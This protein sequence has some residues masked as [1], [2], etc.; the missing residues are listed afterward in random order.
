MTDLPAGQ[1]VPTLY[2]TVVPTVGLPINQ[3]IEKAY[4]F[5]GPYLGTILPG[6]KT[7]QLYSHTTE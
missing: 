4:T 5:L 6:T 2:N 1:I 7:T 3:G